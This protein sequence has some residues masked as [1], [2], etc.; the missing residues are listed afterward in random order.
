MENHIT[1]RKP[2]KK[3]DGATNRALSFKMISIQTGAGKQSQ[4]WYMKIDN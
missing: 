1:Y 4:V 2:G 3:N